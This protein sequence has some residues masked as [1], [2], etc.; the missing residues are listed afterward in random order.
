MSDN[1][2]RA[3]R[4]GGFFLSDN[5]GGGACQTLHHLSAAGNRHGLGAYTARGCEIRMGSEKGRMMRK[6]R[7][8]R[9]YGWW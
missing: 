1:S 9:R 7:A 8:G 5:R 3:V 4:K 2:D 6:G